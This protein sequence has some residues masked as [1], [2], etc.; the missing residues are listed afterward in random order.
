[1]E[2]LAASMLGIAR[3]YFD[4]VS[5]QLG[6]AEHVHPRQ[7]PI[8]GMLLHNEGMSQADLARALKVTPATVAVSAA[9]LE[10][11][12]LI[13]RRRNAR[14]QRANVLAL[15]QTGRAK[16]QRLLEAM[17]A[18]RLAAFEGFSEEELAQLDSY[19]ARMTQN[20]R[21]RYQSGEEK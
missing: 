16:A 17:E 2:G 11:L 6:E 3:L 18:V 5:A 15:T 10:R 7:A 4:C 1:M 21:G 12:G 9:R 8:L 13:C 14:N 20:L 19:C